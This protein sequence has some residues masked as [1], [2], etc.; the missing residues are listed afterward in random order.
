MMKNNKNK[1]RI[2]IVLV[3]TLLTI[4][5]TLSF[6]SDYL[7]DNTLTLNTNQVKCYNIY[8]QNPYGNSNVQKVDLLEGSE[9]IQNLNNTTG[10]FNVPVGTKGGEYPLCF[11]LKLPSNH[12]DGERHYVEYG[13]SVEK[14]EESM[15]SLGNVQLIQNFYIS[16]PNHS[17]PA[18][19]CSDNIKNQDETGVDCGGVC[20]ACSSSDNNNGGSSGGGGSSSRSSSDDDLINVTNFTNVTEV[21]DVTDVTE[22]DNTPLFFE[23]AQ[24]KTTSSNLSEIE[25]LVEESPEIEQEEDKEGLIWVL[26]GGIFV[27]IIIGASSFVIKSRRG[28]DAF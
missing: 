9:Y 22:N 25:P 8:L 3:L 1:N 6:S 27:S 20:P 17:T 10:I 4:P 13:V 7:E 2:W 19:T 11:E 28:E 16:D 23:P 21:T 5:L 15:A 14:D 26:L 24:T 18:L 12:Q